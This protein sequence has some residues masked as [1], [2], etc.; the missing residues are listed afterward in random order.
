MAYPTVYSIYAIGRGM[1]D[2]TYPYFFLNISELGFGGVAIWVAGLAGVF[3]V[4]GA[5]IIFAVK[6]LSSR[7]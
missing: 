3:L 4:A 1:V 2:G 5:V 6:A 7:A